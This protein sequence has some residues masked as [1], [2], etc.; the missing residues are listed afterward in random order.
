MSKSG[1]YGGS[2]SIIAQAT[3]G[4]AALKM[5]AMF[6]IWYGFNAAYNVYNAF[7]KAELPFPFAIAASQLGV[8]LLY[9]IPMW[10]LKLRTSPSMSMSDIK[11]I[12]PVVLLNAIGHTCTVTAMF[13]KGGGSFT[14]V[15]KAAEPVV[16]VILGLVLQRKVPKPLTA[17]SLIPI[18]YGVAYA[19]TLGN[20]SPASM[21][22]ELT[23]LS[24]KLAMTSNVMF[25]WRSIVRSE[26][27]QSF[28]ERTKLD[29]TNEFALTTLLSFALLLPVV[30]RLEGFGVII[31]SFQGNAGMGALVKNIFACGM[32]FYL[33]NEMQNNV[34]A[35]LGPVPT[36]VGNTLKRVVI[37]VALFFFTQGEVFPPAKILGC[38]IAVAGCLAYAV[39]NAKQI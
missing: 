25:A 10:V 13:Q 37:F 33:Y 11:R 12:M 23:T 6:T 28:K 4:G 1:Y 14:H 27:P 39:C 15:I 26:L 3:G 7:V 17:L 24:A 5:A 30:A 35:S 22:K 19:S 38:A 16:S 31:S 18:T 9:A 36:A 20:L 21:K 8:G 29:A 32:C 34:L 2:N